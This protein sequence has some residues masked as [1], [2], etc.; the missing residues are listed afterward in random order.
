MTEV[1][2]KILS[3][4]FGRNY[5]LK[6]AREKVMGMTK[7]VYPAPLKILDVRLCFLMRLHVGQIFELTCAVFSF[8]GS[9]NKS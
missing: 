5:V 1:M 6:Q 2:D 9:A 3:V 8:I 7:G 4:E